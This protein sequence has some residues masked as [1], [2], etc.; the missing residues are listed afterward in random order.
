M[1]R[2]FRLTVCVQ[3]VSCTSEMKKITHV[4]ANSEYVCDDVQGRVF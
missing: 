2:F 4:Y 3:H 1:V